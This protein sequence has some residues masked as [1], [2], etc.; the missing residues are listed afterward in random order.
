MDAFKRRMTGPNILIAD[1]A[2]GTQLTARG[3]PV[4]VA[5]EV[6]NLKR[7]DEVRAVA[8]S[9]VAAGADVIL[10][11]TLGGTRF[12]LEHAGLAARVEEVNRAA[13]ALAK[14]A[15]G[16]KAL[17]F[18]SIGPTGELLEPLGEVTE[19]DAVAAF[20]EQVRGLVAGGVDGFCIESFSDLAE[21]KAALR[22]ARENSSLPAVVS[23]TFA[24]GA[25]GYATMMGVTPEQ[26][27]RELDAAGADVVGANCGV[28]SEQAVDIARLMRPATKLPLWIKPNAGLPRLVGGK[29]VFPESP[30]EFVAHA[31]AIARAGAKF[32]GGCCGTTPAH[33]RLL[34]E[35]LRKK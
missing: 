33:I 30:E 35:T 32:V 20:A 34:A 26:A 11:N 27:A 6:W 8:A 10:T 17:V 25:R 18:A 15:A 28:G 4:E 19:A 9:Y 22:A 29:T 21:A 13:A 31:V 12:K 16:E 24:K 23:M 7:P 14:E 3:L 1:G 2:T 5:H